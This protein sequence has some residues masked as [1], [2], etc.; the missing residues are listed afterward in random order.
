MTSDDAD[1]RAQ[2]YKAVID[3]GADVSEALGS[4]P[5]EEPLVEAGVIPESASKDE[6]SAAQHRAEV[7]SLLEQ[8]LEAVQGGGS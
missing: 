2:A 7:R 3:A 6:M 5:P 8:I 4:E 1:K